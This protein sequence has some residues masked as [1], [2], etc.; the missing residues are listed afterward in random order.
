MQIFITKI[1]NVFIQWPHLILFTSTPNQKI[2]CDY[3]DKTALLHN[4]EKR[5]L[6]FILIIT[7]HE[8]RIYL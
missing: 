4:Y 7:N 1:K 8:F 2:L 3:N 5:N 6:M